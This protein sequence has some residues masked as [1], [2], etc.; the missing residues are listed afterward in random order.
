MES[1]LHANLPH[2]CIRLASIWVNVCCRLLKRYSICL[3]VHQEL[4]PLQLF[5]FVSY[6]CFFA[7]VAI[8][9][10]LNKK[11]MK[12]QKK[13]K[14]MLCWF[15][16]SWLRTRR[17]IHYVLYVEW[18]LNL[19]WPDNSIKIRNRFIQIFYLLDSMFSL[20]FCFFLREYTHTICT[21]NTLHSCR[22]QKTKHFNWIMGSTIH[23]MHNINFSFFFFIHSSK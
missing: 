2:T 6:F 16:I 14:W 9:M 23:F 18:C 7:F 10:T 8:S 3:L 13:K 11:I 1:D 21:Q 20:I 15:K 4:L 12:H 19:R 22:I 17:D 5:R